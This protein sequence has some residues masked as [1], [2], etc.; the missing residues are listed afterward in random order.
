MG[1]PSD[2]TLE[3]CSGENSFLDSQALGYEVIVKVSA[4]WLEQGERA[5]I[6]TTVQDQIGA[7]HG[8]SSV[9][10]SICDSGKLNHQNDSIHNYKP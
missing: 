7:F 5:M 6:S 3:L 2:E 4:W 10:L 8:L 9:V 1:C